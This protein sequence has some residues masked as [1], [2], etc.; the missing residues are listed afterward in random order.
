MNILLILFYAIITCTCAVALMMN[1]SCVFYQCMDCFSVTE[2]CCDYLKKQHCGNH[3]DLCVLNEI[4]VAAEKTCHLQWNVK[5]E[6]R[7]HDFL[8]FEQ[9]PTVHWTK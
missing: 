7:F 8:F 6:L 1:K 4:A 9:L 2:G 3:S 5:L